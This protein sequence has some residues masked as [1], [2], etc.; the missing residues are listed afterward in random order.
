MHAILETT[1]PVL[2]VH[3][4]INTNNTNCSTIQTLVFKTLIVK[5]TIKKSIFTR[6][7]LVRAV[8]TGHE[9][10]EWKKRHLSQTAK[11]LFVVPLK[12]LRQGRVYS[13]ADFGKTD[14]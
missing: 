2:H 11:K 1:V 9:A 7:L 13:Y 5:V 12:S 4:Y 3:R 10:T 6:N 8:A 14:S